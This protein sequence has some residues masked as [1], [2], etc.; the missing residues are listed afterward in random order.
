MWKYFEVCPTHDQPHQAEHR[1]ISNTKGNVSASL[2]P[3]YGWGEPERVLMRCTCTTVHVCLHRMDCSRHMLTVWCIIGPAA[4]IVSQK[5]LKCLGR[6]S[7]LNTSIVSGSRG[8]QGC[9]EEHQWFGCWLQLAYK[10]FRGVQRSSSHLGNF[11]LDD[12]YHYEAQ[13]TIGSTRFRD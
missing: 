1:L 4:G 5:Q 2:A 6:S 10:V 7:S 11:F 8:C 12:F 13:T 3:D 9:L